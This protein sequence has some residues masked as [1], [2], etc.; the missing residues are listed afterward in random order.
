M[1]RDRSRSRSR[2]P[3]PKLSLKSLGVSEISE[4]DYFQKNSEFRLWLREE[5]G[6]YFDELSGERA[7]HYF[8]KFVKAWN[9]GKLPKDLYNA[10]AAVESARPASSQTSYRW[11]FADNGIKVNAAELRAAR[12][13]V[14]QATHDLDAPPTASTAPKRIQGPTLPSGRIMGPSMPS[15]SDLTLH[16]EEAVESARGERR[17]ANKRARER[18]DDED[19]GVGPKA[20]GREGMMEKKRARRDEDRA[21]RDRK[22]DGGLEV[23]ESTLMGAGGNDSFQAA[24]ARRD[25]ARARWAEKKSTAGSGSGPSNER[26]EAMRAREAETMAMFQNMAKQRFG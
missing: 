3:T 18:L 8:R 20:V 5:R 16:Q 17:A 25:A 22:E 24:I 9:R 11:S 13:A 15:A 14:S 2:S 7:R 12:E 21:M 23:N 26:L 10:D 1:P 6:K 19:G 4:S